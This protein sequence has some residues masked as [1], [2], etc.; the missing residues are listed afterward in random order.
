MFVYTVLL[1]LFIVA[2]IVIRKPF[3]LIWLHKIAIKVGDA[4][5]E[6]NTQL[7]KVFFG[8]K[9]DTPPTT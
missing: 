7:I 2:F 9:V 1:V 8:K 5:L 4:L 6:A 3:V